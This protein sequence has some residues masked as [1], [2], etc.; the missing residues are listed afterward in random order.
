MTETLSY[1]MDKGEDMVIPAKS[2][3]NDKEVTEK[4]E[5][6]SDTKSSKEVIENVM[7][8]PEK[9]KSRLFINNFLN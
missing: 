9:E 5:K 3:G 7:H 6:V 8:R 2:N 4:E 1:W